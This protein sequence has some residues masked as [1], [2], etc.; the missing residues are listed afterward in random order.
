MKRNLTAT[1]VE[2]IAAMAAWN[3]Q[4]SA[5]IDEMSELALANVE[6]LAQYELPEV[7]ITCDAEGGKCW[8]EDPSKL[9]WT[10]FGPIRVTVCSFSGW[11]SDYCLPDMPT[12]HL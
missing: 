1:F 4:K 5:K 8:A 9:E 10:P 11:Q 12:N 6:A 7:T 2:A 3:V